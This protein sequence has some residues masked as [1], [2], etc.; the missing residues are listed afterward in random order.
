M[1]LE[2]LR[3]VLQA[4]WLTTQIINNAVCIQKNKHRLEGL[5]QLVSRCQFL[6]SK[7][8]NSVLIYFS[9]SNCNLCAWLVIMCILTL[10]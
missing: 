6:L 10:V 1:Q 3:I 4:T 9:G 8:C 7:Q 2:Y 5:V